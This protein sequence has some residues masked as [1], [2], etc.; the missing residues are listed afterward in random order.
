MIWSGLGTVSRVHVFPLRP[1]PRRAFA[2]PGFLGYLA[3][4]ESRALLARLQPP[5]AGARR[6]SGAAAARAREVP[7]DRQ[8]QPGRVLPGAGGGTARAGRRGRDPARR[9]RT[10]PEGPARRDPP[11]GARAAAR[12]GRDAAEGAGPE[13]RRPADPPGRLERAR[14]ARPLAA[15][16]HV[17]GRDPAGAD[18]AVG[19]PRAPVPVH[20]E[21]VAEPGGGRARSRDRREPL[22]A[23]EGAAPA[24]RASTRCPTASA[25]CRSSS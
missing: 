8:H 15:R 18:A 25:S 23:G 6:G 2:L 10:H 17:R 11:R 9:R 3:V 21:P 22:R 4:P 1:D 12:P 13:A 14:R 16:A 24:R 20:L 7:G 19:R 5:G